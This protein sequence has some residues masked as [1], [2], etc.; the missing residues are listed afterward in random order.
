MSDA[1]LTRDAVL[2][3]YGADRGPRFVA[4]EGSW[5]I[6][7]NGGRFLDFTAGIGV[8]ALGH[9]SSVVRE[10]VEQA[11]ATGLIHTS[12]L[13]RTGPAEDLAAGLVERTFPGQAFF[14]NSGAEAVEAALKFARRWAGTRGGSEKHEFVA[15]R[16]SFHGR[17]F[18]ALAVTDRP[19]YQEPF[20]PL[21]PGAHFA[22]VGDLDAVARLLD[23]S[24]TAA[25]II[26]PIQ[27]EGGVHPV[28][29]RFLQELRELCTARDVALIFDEVQC[30]LGRSGTL[31]AFE[32]SG[33]QPDLL[34][35][36]KPLAGGLPMGA[37]VVGDPVA[38]SMQKGDHAT[39]FGGGPLVATVALAVLETVAQPSF[40]RGVRERGALIEAWAASLLSRGD[41][42]AARGRGLMWGI[43]IAGSSSDVVSRARDR[44]L[45]VV[46]A[47]PHVVRLLPALNVPF[48]ELEDGLALLEASLA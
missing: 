34:A 44:G 5:L 43:Q 28:P 42:V 16:R 20:Q 2:G 21:M 30:G 39:T 6:D 11:L 26:E 4:G 36:A 40:L 27:G 19:S 1:T 13:F 45:L 31:F 14:A 3:V 10:A 37:V 8:N 12:N 29:P 46:G 7:E 18:G 47:G 38:Q 35:L 15:F 17:L 33:V 41:V 22:E 24:S 25:V 48:Q 9:G 32:E 23:R